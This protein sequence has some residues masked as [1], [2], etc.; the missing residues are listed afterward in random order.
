MPVQAP[1]YRPPVTWDASDAQTLL[2]GTARALAPPSLVDMPLFAAGDPTLLKKPCVAVIGSRRV[3]A[4]GAARARRV[5]QE[6]AQAQIVVVSGLAEGV[7]IEAMRSAVAEGGKVVGVIGTPLDT[8]FPA[9]HGT[10]QEEVYKD[11]LLV[12]Q[13]ALGA[14]VSPRN[15]PAR[16]RLMALL[17]DATIIVEAADNSGT[18]HQ[19]AACVRLSRWLF[20]LRNVINDDSLTWPVKYRSYSKCVV[21]DRIVDVVDR[22]S[23]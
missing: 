18:L 9:Q 17:S 1:S 13:F 21:I 2:E 20:I 8:A 14:H 3:S 11:H 15:F 16:N 5:A 12:S 4:D 10:F 22:L 7:D 6:L 19:A 23:Q